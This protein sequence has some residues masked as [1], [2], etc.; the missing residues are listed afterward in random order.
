MVMEPDIT[1]E[2]QM[3]ENDQPHLDWLTFA[4]HEDKGKA[5]KHFE[6]ALKDPWLSD[7]HLRIIEKRKH[8]IS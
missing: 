5:E 3:L 4:W 2:I 6:Q 1:F 7:L 8:I